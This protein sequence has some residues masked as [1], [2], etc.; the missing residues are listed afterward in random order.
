MDKFIALNG[1]R[2][3]YL[4]SGGNKPVF[5]WL[6]DLFG[7]AYSLSGLLEAGLDKYFRVLALT[8]RGRGQSDK[9]EEGYSIIEYG[10]DVISFMD[11]LGL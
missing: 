7:T 6:H 3:H 4:D 1:I 11:Q 2:F 10:R 9:P 5:L 8:M